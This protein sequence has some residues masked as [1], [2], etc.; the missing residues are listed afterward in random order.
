MIAEIL[1][2]EQPVPSDQ[3]K[4]KVLIVDDDLGQLEILRY[5]LEGQGFHVIAASKGCQLF[6]YV[7][8][9]KPDAI[10]LDISLPDASGLEL[11]RELTDAP[12]TS[13]IPVVILS[14][15]DCKRVV[16]NAR[17][18]GCRYFLRKPFDPNAMLLVLKEAIGQR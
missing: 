10:V 12:K 7:V 2:E 4:K 8:D 3:I 9:E 11:C 13:H 18:A 16:R 6:E 17:S 15:S 1:P 14:G 5:G